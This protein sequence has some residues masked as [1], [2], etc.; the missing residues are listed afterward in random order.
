MINCSQNTGK[1][2][3]LSKEMSIFA[4]VKTTHETY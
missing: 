2:L 3:F 1:C 4:I